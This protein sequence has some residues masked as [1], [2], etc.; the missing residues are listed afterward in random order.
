MSFDL[1]LLFWAFHLCW[2]IVEWNVIF[3]YIFSNDAYSLLC[4]FCY[5]AS[6]C[7]TCYRCSTP[8]APYIWIFILGSVCYTF[9]I[10][11]IFLLDKANEVNETIFYVRFAITGL[12]I[13]PLSMQPEETFGCLPLTVFLVVLALSW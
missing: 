7:D 5:W 3:N 8:A 12:D 2:W 1:C 6:Y 10:C 13:S 9:R 11:G 4:F